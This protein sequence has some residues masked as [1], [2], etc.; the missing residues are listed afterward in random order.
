MG[1]WPGSSSWRRHGDPGFVFFFF[2]FMT[3]QP[4]LAAPMPQ[5]P[6]THSDHHSWPLLWGCQAG[7]W[8]GG[9]N[10]V[11]C[12]FRVVSLYWL[13]MTC[14][15]FHFLLAKPDYSSPLHP[16]VLLSW[17]LE[18]IL[19]LW[20]FFSARLWLCSWGLRGQFI[21]V[22]GEPLQASHTKNWA[23]RA[24]WLWCSRRPNQINTICN[25]QHIQV[26]ISP[27]ITPRLSTANYSLWC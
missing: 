6:R 4:N 16:R 5:P 3:K 14:D 25:T 22:W 13:V 2:F 23:L 11:D 12:K 15:V 9:I 21:M 27:S 10:K 18:L 20:G 1:P 17:L 26:A 8:P 7:F 19:H 24:A